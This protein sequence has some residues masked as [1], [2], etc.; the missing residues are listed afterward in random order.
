MAAAALKEQL[1]AHI[2]SMYATGMVDEQ[3]QQLQMLQDDGSSPGFVAEVVTLFCDDAERIITELTKL[4]EQPVV[5][6]DKVDAY[7]HQLKG[8]SAS[9]GAQKV[10]FTCMQ[11]RQLCQD[12]NRD[13]CIMALTVVRSEFYDIKNKFQTMLQLEQQIAAQQ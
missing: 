2:N 3:F 11:F 7:V 13:G 10:K 8:S 5:D 1:N 4:L 6:F 12:K 9:V